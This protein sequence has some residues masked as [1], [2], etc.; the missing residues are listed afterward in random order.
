MLAPEG[1]GEI[2]GRLAAE[3]TTSALL[4]KRLEE[5]KLPREA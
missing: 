3:S 4:E 5:H 2:I 1:Y